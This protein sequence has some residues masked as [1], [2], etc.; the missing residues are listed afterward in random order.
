MKTED[1]RSLISIAKSDDTIHKAYQGALKEYITNSGFI[2]QLKEQ[3][4]LSELD[5]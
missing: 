4:L 2:P 3:I 5:R 1:E